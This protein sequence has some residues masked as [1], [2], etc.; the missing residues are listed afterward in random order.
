MIIEMPS[1]FEAPLSSAQA[2]QLLNLHPN[3]LLL[4]A[5]EDRMGGRL[6]TP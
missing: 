1:A 3:T 4:W 2:A 5:R 6:P